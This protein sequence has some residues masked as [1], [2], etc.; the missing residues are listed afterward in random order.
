LGLREIAFCLKLIG[1]Q[2]QYYFSPQ[3]DAPELVKALPSSGR[4][5][6][7]RLVVVTA[8]PVLPE[9]FE[10]FSFPQFT[11][12]MSKSFGITFFFLICFLGSI[13]MYRY[14]SHFVCLG[15]AVTPL[16]RPTLEEINLPH[17]LIAICHIGY[18]SGDL[19]HHPCSI[20]NL[21]SVKMNLKMWWRRRVVLG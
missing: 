7:T 15:A 1:R 17:L 6:A 3:D 5:L 2:H 12:K 4:G 19:V 20:H 21:I 14:N 18:G 9:G 10:G 11:D 16:K 13:L 8:G